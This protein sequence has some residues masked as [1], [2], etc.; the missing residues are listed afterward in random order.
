MK[1]RVKRKNVETVH[2]HTHTH[3]N[4]FLKNRI[5]GGDD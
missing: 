4:S 5:S 3:T 1:K 2:T